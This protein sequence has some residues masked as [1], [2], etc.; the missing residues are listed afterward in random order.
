MLQCLQPPRRWNQRLSSNRIS[1]DS[2]SKMGL[3]CKQT[4]LGFLFLSLIKEVRPLTSSKRVSLFSNRVHNNL[5][6][7]AK[8]RIQ[9]SSSYS[10]KLNSNNLIHK[11]S[12]TLRKKVRFSIRITYLVCSNI[13]CINSIIFKAST[14]ISS[15]SSISNSNFFL[16]SR[17]C[18]S[19][20]SSNTPNN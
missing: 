15:F 4:N 20:L 8:A 6:I 18:F 17:I 10:S 5:R 9:S 11:T 2:L 7:K 12:K 16:N 1:L 14:L 3:L 19:F 13:R